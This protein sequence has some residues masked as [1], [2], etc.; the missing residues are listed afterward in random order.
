M[1]FF[2]SPGNFV[3]ESVSFAKEDEIIFP[4]S[5]PEIFIEEFQLEVVR[6]NIVFQPGFF[7]YGFHRVGFDFHFT[8][9]QEFDEL[10][11]ADFRFET[12]RRMVHL[13]AYSIG[14]NFFCP[15][16]RLEV[17]NRLISVF[18]NNFENLS[19]DIQ[20]CKDTDLWRQRIRRVCHNR[21]CGSIPLRI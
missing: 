7:F 18:I 17:Q 21:R 2:I 8:G 11:V 19:I 1:K 5:L 16:T 6:G 15:L 9:L 10:P 14:N 12:I 13:L 4:G 3:S 20:T